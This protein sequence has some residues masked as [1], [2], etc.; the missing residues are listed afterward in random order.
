MKARVFCVL[1]L[2]CT[3]ALASEDEAALKAQMHKDCAELF[4]P[5]GACADL[6]K[7]TRK[8]TRQNADKAGP[9]CAEFESAHKEFFD[10]G[11][12]DPTIHKGQ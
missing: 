7:G 12:N 4:A 10:A 6:V 5:G 2:F 1:A 3:A 9:A 11:M 8:C